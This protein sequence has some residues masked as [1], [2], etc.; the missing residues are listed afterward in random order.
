MIKCEEFILNSKGRVSILKKSV[1]IILYASVIVLIFLLYIVYRGVANYDE[2]TDT[3][4]LTDTTSVA[5]DMSYLKDTNKSY[6]IKEYSQKKG[7]DIKYIQR[8]VG[9]S[10]GYNTWFGTETVLEKENTNGLF[11]GDVKVL[12]YPLEAGKEW[13]INDYSFTIESVNKTIKVPAGTFNHVVEVKTTQK[14]M[15]GYIT[16]YYAK[17]VGQ[18]LR[19]SVD[20]HSKKNIRYEILEIGKKDKKVAS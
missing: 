16:T 3:T 14:G 7:K 2:V 6:I 8:F 13:T 4:E 1:K 19:E 11:Y 15:P 18:I 10:K 9:E 12:A 17:G 20:A 5:K